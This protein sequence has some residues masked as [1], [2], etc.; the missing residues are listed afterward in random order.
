MNSFNHYAYGAVADW[1]YE[2]AAGIRPV[3][4]APGFERIRIAPQ[5][6]ERLQWLEGSIETRRGTVRSRWEWLEINGE[7]K[8]RYEIQTPSPTEILI[9]GRRHEV[10][11]GSYIFFA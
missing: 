4:E 8:I 11:A 3:E 9:G 10:Q 7:K 1:V 6:D 2:V 5:P